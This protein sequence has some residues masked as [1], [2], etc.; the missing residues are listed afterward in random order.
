MLSCMRMVWWQDRLVAEIH[1]VFL[2]IIIIVPVGLVIALGRSLALMIAR[3]DGLEN[4]RFGT[5]AR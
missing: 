4:G 1:V 2:A 3:Y 5:F